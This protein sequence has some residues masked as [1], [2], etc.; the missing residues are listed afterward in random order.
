[1]KYIL[2]PLMAIAT[3]AGMVAA[4]VPNNAATIDYAKYNLM[5]PIAD[6]FAYWPD[7]KDSDPDTRV[8]ELLLPSGKTYPYRLH[9]KDPKDNKY[10]LS[11]AEDADDALAA[12]EEEGLGSSADMTPDEYEARSIEDK[13]AFSVY[14]DKDDK[15]MYLAQG[16]SVPT[17]SKD[18]LS[19][20]E[21]YVRHL[22]RKL[23][24]NTPGIEDLKDPGSIVAQLLLNQLALQGPDVLEDAKNNPDI[25]R[26]LDSLYD[27]ADDFFKQKQDLEAK[28]LK[29]EAG[30]KEKRHN[31]PHHHHK[32]S[33]N[34]KKNA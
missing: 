1:M 8:V 27:S 23:D 19:Q 24:P 20:T 15:I 32:K 16:S 4:V 14:L 28:V 34:K 25:V 3:F 2:A 31:K 26:L 30:K 33:S 17:S 12:I 6:V 18:V 7:H 10:D 29:E 21:A 9:Y 13:V 11:V 5:G 22:N